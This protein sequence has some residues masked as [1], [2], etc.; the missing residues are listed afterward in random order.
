MCVQ[1]VRG[2]LLSNIRTTLQ[3]HYPLPRLWAP[4]AV[5]RDKGEC[6]SHAGYSL[7][8]LAR[9]GFSLGPLCAKVAGVPLGLIINPRR[10]ERRRKRAGGD[11]PAKKT[12]LTGPVV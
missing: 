12:N 9:A 4:R 3:F 7:R 10:G 6:D 1:I 8:P 5:E 2:L 11:G